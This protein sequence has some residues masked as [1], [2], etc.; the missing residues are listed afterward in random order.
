M[1][2]TNWEKKIEERLTDLLSEAGFSVKS[3]REQ[4]ISGIAERADSG[5]DILMKAKS[6]E[7]KEYVLIVEAKSNGEP[8]MARMAIQQLREYLKNRQEA[9]GIFGAP[10]I[11][12][13]TGEL[14]KKEGIGYV[15]AAGNSSLS[16]GPTFIQVKGNPNPFKNEKKLKSLFSPK[17][18]RVLRVMLSNPEKKWFVRDLAE[19]A[20]VSLGQASNVK[21]RLLD[22]EFI[23]KEKK[24]FKLREPE[25]LLQRWVESYSYAKSSA[26]NFYSLQ[27]PR[28]FE[29]LFSQYCREQNIS[30]AFTL[31]S[32]AARVAPFVRYNRVFTYAPE[33]S[34]DAQEQLQLKPVRT[35]ANV[36]ILTPYDAGLLYSLQDISGEKVVCDVQLYLDLK[37]FGGRGE[38]A[39]EMIFEK[40]L[41]PKW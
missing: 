28:E 22:Y 34:L 41:K 35:G 15:D 26:S 18:S 38:E 36:T 31:F 23:I 20:D 29:T 6:P 27:D 11:S 2:E 21:K 24:E 3:S 4:A 7:G 14:C 33:F 30:Y 19:E 39:A 12:K 16:F 25:K 1:K 40:R 13:E 17:S 5:I 32:G 10:F 8:R 37:S 9:Y